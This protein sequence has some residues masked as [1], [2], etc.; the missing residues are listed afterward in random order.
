MNRVRFVQPARLEVLAEVA[1]YH[2]LEAGLGTKFLEAVEDASAHALVYPL[3]G[4]PVQN[5]TRRV[6]LRDFPFALVYRSID[7]PF[8]CLTSA[9]SSYTLIWAK[10]SIELGTHMTVTTA[11]TAVIRQ[12]ESWW[13]GWVEEVPG[14]NAQEQ[15][16]EALLESLREVLLE[17]LE[18]NRQD[19]LEA[20]GLAT[21]RTCPSSGH[22]IPSLPRPNPLTPKTPDQRAQRIGGSGRD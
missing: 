2:R 16:R 12:A 20:A 17:A 10:L 11:F 8:T 4:S 19:A 6:F 21:L 1:Y 3:A 18:L 7:L 5:N 15:S 13:I 14:V 9:G 22:L